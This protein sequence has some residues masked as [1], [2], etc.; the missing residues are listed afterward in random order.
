MEGIDPMSLYTESCSRRAALRRSAQL[1]GAAALGMSALERAAFTASAAAPSTAKLVAAHLD[2]GF[3]LYASLARG[4]TNG[5]NLV[6]SPL[7]IA[8]A[9][10]MTYNGAR[11]GTQTAMARTLGLGSMPPSD[12]NG[13]SAALIARLRALDPA[14]DLSIAD[15]LWLRQGLTVLPAFQQVMLRSYG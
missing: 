13:A 10:S 9:L 11:G 14:I 15:S 5:A 12:L 1:T 7:S 8:L 6:I 3:R 2:F 4:M